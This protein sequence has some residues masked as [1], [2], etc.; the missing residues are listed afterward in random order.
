MRRVIWAAGVAFLLGSCGTAPVSETGP[1]TAPVEVRAS[2]VVEMSAAAQAS[3]GV[4]VMTVSSSAVP[5]VIR[6][7]AKLT[8]DENRTWRVGAVA[9]GRIMRVQSNPGDLVKK[10]QVLA[11]MHSHDIHESRAAYKKAKADYARMQGVE[12]YRLRLKDRAKRLL[13]LRAGS[14]AQYEQAETEW[15]NSQTDTKNAEIEIEKSRT[16]LE[17]VLGI[18]AEE[19]EI[20]KGPD[21][22]DNDLIPIT[23]PARRGGADSQRDAGYGGDALC[24]LVHR[25]RFVQPVGRRRGE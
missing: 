18:P 13:D 10:D 2:N 9:E 8:T 11:S 1:K 17:E 25:E 20:P 7:T 19:E 21:G 3:A 4:R 24:G 22:E 12:E 5:E 15:K 16:H 23:A 6:A 14:V